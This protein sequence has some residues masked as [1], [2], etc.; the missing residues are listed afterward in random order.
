M[1]LVWLVLSKNLYFS[2]MECYSVIPEISYRDGGFRR[3]GLQRRLRLRAL[4]SIG[5]GEWRRNQ[6]VLLGGRGV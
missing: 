1:K 6:G 3:H 4:E 5:E 2:Q